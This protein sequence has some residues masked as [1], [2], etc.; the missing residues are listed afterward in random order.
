MN[1][2]ILALTKI[3]FTTEEA[4]KQIKELNDIILGLVAKKLLGENAE[5]LQSEEILKQKIESQYTKEEIR[6]VFEEVSMETVKGYFDAILSDLDDKQVSD[7]MQEVQKDT[8]QQ[9]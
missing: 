6:K 5:H 3:G 1:N 7:F 2:T 4:E 9:V 8:Q